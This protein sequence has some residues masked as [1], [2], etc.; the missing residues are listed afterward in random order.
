MTPKNFPLKSI[1]YFWQRPYFV[2]TKEI[3]EN[4][5]PNSLILNPNFAVKYNFPLFTCIS[6]GIGHCLYSQLAMM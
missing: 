1:N 4:Q 3:L 5:I 6:R 2:T